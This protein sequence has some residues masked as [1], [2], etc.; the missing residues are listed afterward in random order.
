MNTA[1]GCEA[2]ASSGTA[3][4][5]A[6]RPTAEMLA[7]LPHPIDPRHLNAGSQRSTTQTGCP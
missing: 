4:K 1:L 5:F 7:V 3:P 2:H 6:L